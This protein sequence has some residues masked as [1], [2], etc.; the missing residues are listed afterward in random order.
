V[1]YADTIASRSPDD[2]KIIDIAGPLGSSVHDHI[3]NGKHGYASMERLRSIWPLP[4]P[5]DAI[6]R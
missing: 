3:I 4:A 2:E 6:S 5:Y 1:R